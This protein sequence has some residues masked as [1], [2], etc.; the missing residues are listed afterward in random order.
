MMMNKEVEIEI[1]RTPYET[2]EHFC[3]CYNVDDANKKLDELEQ[4]AIRLDYPSNIN[5][6]RI[7][8][9]ESTYIVLK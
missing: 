4:E 1:R 9:D 2:W 8:V 7:K 3:N 5:N 6:Y